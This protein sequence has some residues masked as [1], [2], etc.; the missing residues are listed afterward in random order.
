MC[1][2]NLVRAACLVSMEF[3]LF[4]AEAMARDPLEVFLGTVSYNKRRFPAWE[5]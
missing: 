4:C 3:P 2:T 5:D 1:G